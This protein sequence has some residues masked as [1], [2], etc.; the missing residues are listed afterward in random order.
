MRLVERMGQTLALTPEAVR[1]LNRLAVDRLAVDGLEAA[2]GEYRVK[3]ISITNTVHKPPPADRVAELV[4]EMCDYA[5]G[6]DR[7]RCTS[8]RT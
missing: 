2:A 8:R 7:P 5:N 1:D 3:Q 4:K 6:P